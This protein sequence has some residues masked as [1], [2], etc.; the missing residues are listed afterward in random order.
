MIIKI[1]EE[2]RNKIRLT[3]SLV[4]SWKEYE[5]MLL[6]ERIQNLPRS[7]FYFSFIVFSVVNALQVLINFHCWS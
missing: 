2:E 4:C 7:S 3:N 1:K 5:K 6:K